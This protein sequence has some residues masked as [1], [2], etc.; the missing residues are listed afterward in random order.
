M[1]SIVLSVPLL[2]IVIIIIIFFLLLFFFFFVTFA[3]LRAPSEV[4]EKCFLVARLV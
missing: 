4:P 2:I 1:L 3:P